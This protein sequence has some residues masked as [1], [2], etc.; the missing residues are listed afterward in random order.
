MISLRSTWPQKRA[1]PV[2]DLRSCALDVTGMQPRSVTRLDACSVYSPPLPRYPKSLFCC[3]RGVFAYVLGVL[4]VSWREMQLQAPGV[5]GQLA[6]AAQVVCFD[7]TRV[8]RREGEGRVEPFETSTIQ[9]AAR[10]V[11]QVTWLQEL[12]RLV[13]AG[14][15]DQ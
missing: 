1:V 2:F 3:I 9:A 5:V 11:V 8:S 4:T 15:S 14:P 6:I 12:L 13:C 7:A 10:A